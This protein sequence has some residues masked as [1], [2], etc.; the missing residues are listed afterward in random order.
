MI[1]PSTTIVSSP[2]DSTPT[3]KPLSE[4]TVDPN[5]INIA[6]TSLFELKEET[7]STVDVVILKESVEAEVERSSDRSK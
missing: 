1:E 7:V 4:G 6:E 5:D 3:K 2:I